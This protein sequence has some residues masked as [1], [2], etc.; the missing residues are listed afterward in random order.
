M[1]FKIISIDTNFCNS[2]NGEPIVSPILIKSF[3]L[4]EGDKVAAYQDE[5]EWEGVIHCDLSQT[6][7]LRWYIQ[8]DPLT[9]K[10]ASNERVVGRNEGYRNGMAI[11]ELIAKIKIAEDLLK[12]GL[13]PEIVC[14]YTK[15]SIE[16][17]NILKSRIR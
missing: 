5:D 7:D 17:I 14:N 10:E 1:P 12:N 15:L 8:L 3:E 9:H 16:R 13:T 2:V 11:G 6:E 4:S